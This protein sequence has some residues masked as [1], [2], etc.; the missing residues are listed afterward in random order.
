V[1]RTL[2][3][4]LALSALTA[5]ASP[6]SAHSGFVS[7]APGDGE[8]M[9]E[10]PAVVTIVFTEPPDPAL[11]EIRVLDAAGTEVGGGDPTAPDPT[12]LSV[13]LPDRVD[14]GVY[15]VH[16]RVVSTV[17]GHLTTGAFSFGV[18]V[19]TAPPPPREDAS[20]TSVRPTPIAVAG[21]ALLT[22]GLMMLIAA[23][24]VGLGVFGGEPRRLDV[25]AM[26]G[27][28]LATAGVVLMVVAEQR[29]VGVSLPELFASTAGRRLLWLMVTVLAAAAFVVLAVARRAWRDALWIAGLEAA[30][31]MWIRA[32]GGHA[33]GAD[34]PLLHR[35]LQSVHF[36]AAGVWIGGVALLIVL[37]AERGR[38]P[39]LAS[40][41]RFSTWASV[42]MG[43]VVITGALR[44]FEEIGGQGLRAALGRPYGTVLAVKVAVALAIVAVGAVNRYRL[45][46]RLAD[47]ARPLFRAASTET[48]LAVAVIA[49]TATLTG[50]DPAERAEVAPVAATDAPTAEGSDFATTA[51]ATLTL[52]PGTPGANAFRAQISRY[53]SEEPLPA[54][55][56]VLRVRSATRPDLPAVSLAMTPDGEAWIAQGTT[57]SV[58]GT[59]DGVLLVRTGSQTIEI[60]VLLVTRSEGQGAPPGSA[61]TTTSFRSGVSLQLFVDPARA[62]VNQVHV[63]AFAPDGSELPLDEAVVVVAPAHGSAARVDVMRFGPGHFVAEPELSG[64]TWTVDVVTQTSDGRVFQATLRD[65]PVPS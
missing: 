15:T 52:T 45:I 39:P 27:A 3:V 40:V 47:G 57:L 12:T 59:W 13:G 63:T 32:G 28:V 31:A 64:G 10:A 54:D 2:A 48:V 56:V 9:A 34:L 29:A 17:D 19:E 61:I 14:E 65:V 20:G 36:V 24:V 42:A 30:A 43:V 23:A 21:R 11:S 22:A 16:W 25:F 55:E 41:R 38:E 58:A 7:S 33:A 62:G 26:T 51:S 50:L 44:A 35:S 53:G 37:L 60:P 6:A 4:A 8:T 49:L 46:P 1:R 5:W 18:G